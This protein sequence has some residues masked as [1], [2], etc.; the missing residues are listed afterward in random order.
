MWT[1]RRP[2]HGE[3]AEPLAA[4]H[5]P[6]GS[7]LLAVFDGSGGSGAAPGWREPDGT[8]HTSAW[9][10]ARIARLAAEC[11]FQHAVA[12][13]EAASG[14]NGPGSADS[15][16][17]LKHWLRRMLDAAP[18]VARSKITGSMRRVLPTTLAAIRYETAAGGVRWEAVWAGDSR[19]YAL[20]P[21]SGLHA[22]TRD[23]THEDDALAQLRQDPPMTNVVCAD[24]EFTLSAHRGE[25]GAP[26]VLLTATDG[27]FGY[28]HTPAQ[29]ECVLLD[30][31]AHAVD[32]ADWAERLRR[33]IQPATGD[34]AS[35]SLA[36]LGFEDFGRLRAAFA[37]RRADLARGEYLDVPPEDD[38]EAMRGWQ[39]RTWQA[40]RDAYETF[41]P[42]VRE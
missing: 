25:F 24:R 14:G 26:C 29:F 34:D 4:H 30:T 9:T 3:D 38:Q 6:T 13:E 32:A 7:G 21:G 28:V 20:L 33:A 2:G 40:Y 19:S 39:D 31:L 15:P 23:D 1:E 17:R 35:L 42:G 22:L 16:E 5:R 41:M 12:P 18:T 8:T 27:F 11:W 10:G 37:G 36:A